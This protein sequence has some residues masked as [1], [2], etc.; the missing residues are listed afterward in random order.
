MKLYIAGPM[1][2]YPLHNWPAFDRE[3]ELLREAGYEVI[4]PTECNGTYEEALRK[5]YEECL[6][7]DI[8]AMLECDALA[9]LPGWENSPG[10]VFEREIARRVGMVA[11]SAYLWRDPVIIAN[12]M[13]GL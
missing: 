12:R 1:T 9:L 11:E 2:G 6:K 7:N 10:A 3:A 4:N 5:P 8:K 13:R